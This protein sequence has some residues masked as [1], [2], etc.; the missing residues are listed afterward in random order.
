MTKT[1][2]GYQINYRLITKSGTI[3]LD[4]WL[5]NTYIGEYKNLTEVYK[6]IDQMIERGL[7]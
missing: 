4:A 3:V 1:Y 5:D 7:M 6:A 2:K